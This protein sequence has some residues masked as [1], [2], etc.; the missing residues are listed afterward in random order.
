MRKLNMFKVKQ[1]KS[2]EERHTN[3]CWW[4]KQ[5]ASSNRTLLCSWLLN[6]KMYLSLSLSPHLCPLVSCN[7]V[8]MIYYVHIYIWALRSHIFCDISTLSLFL[9][10]KLVGYPNNKM[11]ENKAK[12][13]KSVIKF[14]E[15]YF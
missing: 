15:A 2:Q 11:N 7:L 10:T 1:Q 8:T 9:S 3:K 14:I 6:S 12:R 4:G 13:Q 5:L